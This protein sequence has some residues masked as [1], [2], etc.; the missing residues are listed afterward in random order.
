MSSERPNG[1]RITGRPEVDA[2]HDAMLPIAELTPDEAVNLRFEEV[3]RAQ[4]TTD[5]KVNELYAVLMG[6]TP[7]GRPVGYAGIEELP[8]RVAKEVA[9]RLLETFQT[10]IH[11]LQ[12]KDS[13][14]ETRIQDVADEVDQLKMDL[15]Q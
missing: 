5:D 4:K 1:E 8:A 3:L 7:S 14:L 11:E 15:G 2:R 13:E 12:R 9:N 6:A 10:L